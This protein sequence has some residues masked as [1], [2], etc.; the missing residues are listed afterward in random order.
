MKLRSRL[1]PFVSTGVLSTYALVH[2]QQAPPAAI[3]PPHGS[4]AT[5]SLSTV[6]PPDPRIRIGTLDNGLR[7][8]VRHNGRPENRAELRLVVNAGSILEDDDQRGLAHVVEHMAF[9]GTENFPRLDIVAFMESIGMRF[10]PSVNAFTSFDETVYMVQVPTT[11]PATLDRAL[12][13]LEDWA[14]RVT[15]D[16]DEVERERGVVIEEWRGRRGAA[17]RLQD[18]Q[19]PV[20]LDGSLYADR[21]PIG[22][23]AVLENFTRDRLVE[24]Y[25][26]WYRPD[27]MAVIIVGDIDP[28]VVEAQIR[29]RFGAIPTP[30]DAK[31]REAHRVPERSV[32]AFLILTDPEQTVTQVRVDSIGP[33]RDQSTIGSYRRS[34]VENL[35][36]AMLSARFDEIA[37]RPEAPFLAAGAGRSGVVRTADSESL[38]A[39]VADGKVEAGLEALFVE[40]ARAARFG[41]T[42]VELDRQKRILERSLERAV[43]ER[44]TQPSSAYA[45]EYSR[46]FLE[47]EPIPGIVYEQALYERFLPEITLEEINEVA[48]R[49]SPPERRIVMV[50]APEKDDVVLPTA[51]RLADVIAGAPE[52]AT[53]A[54]TA[55]AVDGNLLAARPEPGTIVSTRTLESV[56]IT[57]WALSNGVRVVLKPTPFK[58]DQIVFRAF[59]PGGSSLAPDDNFIPATTAAQ[60]VAA[61]GVGSLSALELERAL[62]GVV[63]RVSPSISAYEEGLNGSG[64]PQDL[65]TLFQ[66]IHL[67]FTAPRAD[68]DIFRVMQDQTSA[69]LANQAASPEYAFRDALNE[70][71]TQGHPRGRLMTPDLV[72]DMD[73]ERSMAF[74]RDRFAD[75]GDFTFVFV[76]AFDLDTMRSLSETYLA[77]LPSA[78]RTETWRD[79]GLRPPRGV[80]ETT[81]ERGLEPRSLSQMIFTGPFE[82]EQAN[83]TAIRAMGLVLQTRLRNTLREDLGGTYSVGVDVSYSRIPAPE[84]RVTI[85]FGSSPERA[86]ELQDRVLVEIEALRQDGPTERELSDVRESLL[87][88]F[89]TGMQDNGY[90]LTQIVGRYRNEENVEDFFAI[91]ETYRTLTAG[92]IHGAAQRYLDPTNMV[93][94]TLLPER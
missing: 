17:A 41:F 16:P 15:F 22:T 52:K 46:N 66:L 30:D 84:Y 87:R 9:N 91:D 68:A 45:S 43:A 93:R 35:F 40:A 90:L 59:S 89:E 6:I 74:Y 88:E 94:A 58:Q 64:S 82:Y 70:L 33:A 85:A 78:G 20:L 73:L 50:T 71:M 48:A 25:R 37:Q 19:I 5:A 81:V 51:E 1:L 65:E 60:V 80:H 55:E 24:F 77:S 13:I 49:W 38:I 54:W 83:R 3:P 21:L 42:E 67:R 31:P 26:D 57:E 62:A 18:R 4:P 44:E 53:T 79:I 69:A 28:D 39:V 61:G 47:G 12:L 56:G 14:H 8:Y 34:I 63:A 11:D 76:G 92:D 2:A 75:A 23:T 29:N 10:G 7:Y 36:S 72:D 32:P 27:L 86:R